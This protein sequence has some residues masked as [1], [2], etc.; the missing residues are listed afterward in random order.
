MSVENNS[1]KS[2]GSVGLEWKNICYSVSVPAAKRGEKT[3]K[4]LLNNVNGFLEAGQVL[5]LLSFK[6]YLSCIFSLL[7]YLVLLAL[8]R[9]P[10]WIYSP[11]VLTEARFLAL[12]PFKEVVEVKNL[13]KGKLG[14]S[15]KKILCIEHWRFV[16]ILNTLRVCVYP[17]LNGH[18]QK[19]W[20]E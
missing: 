8:V 20:L 13:G 17:P 15:S 10:C 3:T 11:V 16:K 4:Q 2:S 5:W 1:N 19:N 12:S 7:P 18:L 14:M 9:P 6:L